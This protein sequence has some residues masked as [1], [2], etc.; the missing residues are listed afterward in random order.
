MIQLTK[1]KNLSKEHQKVFDEVAQ[2][3]LGN[4]VILDSEPSSSEMKP[5][6]GKVKDAVDYIYFKFPDGKTV[7]ISVTEV[8]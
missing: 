1:A 2:N 5:G 8:T 3:A 4:P 7:K 6:I